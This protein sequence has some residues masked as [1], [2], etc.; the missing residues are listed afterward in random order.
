MERL[1]MILLTATI[2]EE[3]DG[4]ILVQFNGQDIMGN[5]EAE[6]DVADAL[7]DAMVKKRDEL[8][9]GKEWTS[10]PLRHSYVRKFTNEEERDK[11]V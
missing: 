2:K 9:A 6:A 3:E 1:R 10:H 4:S 5:T 11:R 7:K 8:F